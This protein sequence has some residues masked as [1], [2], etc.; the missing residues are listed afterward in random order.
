MEDAAISI[1]DLLYLNWSTSDPAKDLTIRET[2][3]PSLVCFTTREYA[4]NPQRI[5]SYQVSVISGSVKDTAEEVGSVV[6]YR[7]EEQIM[8]HAWAITGIGDDFKT[9]QRRVRNMMDS[10]DYVLR[11]GAAS[12]QQTGI[13]FIRISPGWRQPQ[14]NLTRALV[15]HRVKEATAVYYRT[16]PSVPIV[17]PSAPAFSW[18]D[19]TTWNDG[20][21]W[22]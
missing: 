8:I 10:I 16:E 21:G 1:L 3:L 20:G 5:H 7:V 12:T 4:T 9:V 22:S 17:S 2:F 6:M 14:D 19:G 18:N 13:Q 15:F 11:I